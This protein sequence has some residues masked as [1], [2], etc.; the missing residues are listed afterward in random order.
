MVCP[1]SDDRRLTSTATGAILFQC[2]GAKFSQC[3]SGFRNDSEP[4][5]GNLFR[6]G[7]HHLLL[8]LRSFFRKHNRNLRHGYRS[9]SQHQL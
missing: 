3:F 8:E 5:V 7:N 2:R 6:D 9:E 1:F 4:V